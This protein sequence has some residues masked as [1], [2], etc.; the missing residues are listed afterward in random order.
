[1]SCHSSPHCRLVTLVS[2]ITLPLCSTFITKVSSLLRTAPPLVP[3]SVF[4]LMVSAICYFPLHSER[5]SHVPYQSLLLSSC[6]LYTD[7]H[8]IR[9]QASFR[10]IP[11]IEGNPSFDSA[12]CIS[13]C[14]IGRFAFAHLLNTY[15]TPLQ[16]PF[17][18]SFT[19]APFERSSTG[20]LEVCSCKPTPGGLLPSSVQHRKLALAFVT[21]PSEYVPHNR[22]VLGDINLRR[23]RRGG[24]N[25]R[26]AR[27]IFKVC[28]K[29]G[30]TV[31]PF[32]HAFHRPAFPPPVFGRRDVQAATAL[33]TPSQFCSK[34]TGLM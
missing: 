28:G 7:C 32:S 6:R 13:R 29:G 23:S 1:M 30:K 2:R 17:P 5:S 21:H 22:L 14:V 20:R 25:V 34:S 16:M 15:L 4:F 9:Q 26:I 3:T 19:T 11:G 12:L 31:L 33:I 10:L 8:R 24:G 27:A 18:K